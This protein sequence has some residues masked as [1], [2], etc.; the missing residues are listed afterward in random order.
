MA[1]RGLCEGNHHVTIG[2][3]AYAAAAAQGLERTSRSVTDSKAVALEAGPAVGVATA[4]TALAPV[5]ALA[6]LGRAGAVKRADVG[7]RRSGI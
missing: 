1:A 7:R 6:P 5:V 3:L 2:T 4:G